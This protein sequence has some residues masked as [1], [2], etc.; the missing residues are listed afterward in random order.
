[1]ITK[2]VIEELRAEVEKIPASHPIDK[3]YVSINS[4]GVKYIKPMDAVKWFLD[5]LEGKTK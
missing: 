3:S 5:Y 1:M 2:E 4:F